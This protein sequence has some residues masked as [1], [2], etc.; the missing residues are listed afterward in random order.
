MSNQ[1]LK[2]S[3]STTE[4]ETDNL[5]LKL[6]TSYTITV[7][8]CLNHTNIDK[9]SPITLRA[10]FPTTLANQPQLNVDI[11][12]F[13]GCTQ[14]WSMNMNS[15]KIEKIQSLHQQKYHPKKCLVI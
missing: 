4:T 3:V 7:E 12:T 2:I 15:Q 9:Y 1:E 11:M 5:G 13:V 14:D 6:Y 10:P 8:V